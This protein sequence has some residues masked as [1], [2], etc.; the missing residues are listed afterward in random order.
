MTTTSP[1]YPGTRA[2]AAP[3]SS[4][5]GSA[6]PAEAVGRGGD[7]DTCWRALGRAAQGRGA[8]VV[9]RGEAGMGKSTLLGSVADRAAGSGWRVLRVSGRDTRARGAFGAF[10]PLAGELLALAVGLPDL[11][12]T[13]LRRALEGDPAPD[14]LSTY[15]A[16]RQVLAAAAQRGPVLLVVDDCHLLDTASARPSRS[17]PTVCRARP[18][19]CW[20]PRR[21]MS[22]TPSTGARSRRCR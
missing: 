4:A 15:A 13:A 19:P 20:R 9:V 22:A 2:E 7:L 18:S 21:S 10:E 12:R 16:L 5:S 3:R 1:P 6:R 11:L 14:A 8:A 17:S